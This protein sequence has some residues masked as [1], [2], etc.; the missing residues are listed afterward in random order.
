M[1]RGGET[2]DYV[3]KMVPG[4]RVEKVVGFAPKRTF[5]A[6]RYDK[7]TPE[8][9]AR[10]DYRA[11]LFWAP[12]IQTDATGKATVS[13]YTSDAKTSLHM[14]LDGATVSGRPGHAEATMKV[15]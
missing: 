10:P 1:K 3:N 2:N 8:E 6:P 11:T 13:F 9:K 7:P 15:E 12:R 5:Y 14:V 4:V